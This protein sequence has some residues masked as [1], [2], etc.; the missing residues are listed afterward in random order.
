MELHIRDV[1]KTYS[2]GVQAL[3]DVTLT[4]PAGM[5]GLLGH[6]F[7]GDEGA[8][9][10]AQ[11]RLPYAHL[12]VRPL[13][14]KYLRDRTTLSTIPTFATS[15]GSSTSNRTLLSADVISNGLGK[16]LSS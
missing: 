5:Y 16:H 9:R 6:V 12:K 4:V 8:R 14:H 3:K 11:Q 2:N 10:D 13:S 15:C 7:V 1:S